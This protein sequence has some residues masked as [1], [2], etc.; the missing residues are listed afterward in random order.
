[1]DFLNIKTND[2]R[3]IVIFKKYEYVSNINTAN[4]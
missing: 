4:S 1:M 2:L 3:K